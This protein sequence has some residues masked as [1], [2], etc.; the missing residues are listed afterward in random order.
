MAD[1]PVLDGAGNVIVPF[2]VDPAYVPPDP[3]DYAADYPVLDG[4]GNVVIADA[5]NTGGGLGPELIDG[6]DFASPAGWDI[7]GGWSISGGKGR[8]ASGT[9]GALSKAFNSGQISGPCSFQVALNVDEIAGSVDAYLFIDGGLS[10]VYN[11]MEVGFQTYRV[12]TQDAAGVLFY[13]DAA[14]VVLDNVSVR[15]ILSP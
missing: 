5:L 6:G 1:Y 14:S 7:G 15:Q 2:A 11:V 4:A 8:H 3:Y 10:P 12:D 9:A 13:A